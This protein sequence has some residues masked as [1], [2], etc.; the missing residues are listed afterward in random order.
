DKRKRTTENRRSFFVPK[1]SRFYL[2]YREF[3]GIMLNGVKKRTHSDFVLCLPSYTFPVFRQE[4]AEVEAK[5]KNVEE[6]ITG[7]APSWQ[8]FP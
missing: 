6:K 4:Y 5:L 8:L 3:Y 7:G 1:I 2:Y